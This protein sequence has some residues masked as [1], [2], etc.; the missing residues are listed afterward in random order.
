MMKTR[1]ILI[2]ILPVLLVSCL[3]VTQEEEV[4]EKIDTAGLQNGLPLDNIH[5]SRGKDTTHNT[6]NKGIPL[7]NLD[8]DKR[9]E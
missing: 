7:D 9:E 1:F 8:R 6:V 5:R 2:A 3:G 4:S